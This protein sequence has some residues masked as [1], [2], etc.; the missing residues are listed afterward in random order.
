VAV[1][2]ASLVAVAVALVLAVAVAMAMAVAVACYIIGSTLVL[3]SQL[4]F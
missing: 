4:L 2:V 3:T 1:V